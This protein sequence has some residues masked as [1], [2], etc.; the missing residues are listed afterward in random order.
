VPL[1]QGVKRMR[2]EP[3]RLFLGYAAV[4]WILLGYVVVRSDSRQ[5]VST[6]E[7]PCG[8]TVKLKQRPVNLLS[9]RLLKSPN[10]FQRGDRLGA[11]RNEVASLSLVC[12]TKG[13]S[14]VPPNYLSNGLRGDLP[15]DPQALRAQ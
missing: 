10:R 2:E 4:L 15:E 14:L 5:P 13:V 7:S 6:T 3:R 11:K 1:P 9:E 8:K 12:P